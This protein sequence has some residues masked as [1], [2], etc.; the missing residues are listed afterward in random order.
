MGGGK[1]LTATDVWV[2]QYLC[3]D[4]HVYR[5]NTTYFIAMSARPYAD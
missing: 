1:D 3:T 2:D 4:V 5:Y